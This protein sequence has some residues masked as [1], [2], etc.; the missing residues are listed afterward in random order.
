MHVENNPDFK[1]VW[2]LAHDWVGEKPDQTD[3]HAISSELRIAIDR[4]IRA[5]GSKEISARWK[6]YKI[7]IDDSFL[8]FIFDFWHTIKFY[9]WLM[10]NKFSKDYLD[11]LYVKR[12]E[13]I[14]WCDKVALLDP[15]PCWSPKTYTAIDPVISD[16]VDPDDENNSWYERIT[17]RRRQRVVCIE[18][19]KQLW[20]K[21]PDLNYEEM[22]KH[23][24]MQEFG[25]SSTFSSK[26]FRNLVRTVAS[27]SAQSP[28]APTKSKD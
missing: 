4:L 28:G 25:Y 8:S 2:Q 21:N 22:Q 23:P 14:T 9:Q 19:A 24:I 26:S 27:D 17:E 16:Q 1:T 18:L 3:P 7:F 5:M 12:N 10:H 6:G 15:P 11:N 20:E 13:V